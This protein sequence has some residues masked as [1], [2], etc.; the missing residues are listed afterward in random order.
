MIYLRKTPFRYSTKQFL[1]KM[2]F[3]SGAFG[4]NFIEESL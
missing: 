4:Q 2:F 3:E 1:R